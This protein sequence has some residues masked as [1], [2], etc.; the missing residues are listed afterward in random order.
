MTKESRFF[1]GSGKNYASYRPTYPPELG[2]TLAALG[3]GNEYALDVGCGNGQLTR[4]L[5]HHFRQVTGT[6]PSASQLRHAIPA[7]NVEYRQQ[8]AEAI[9]LHGASADLIVAAQAAHWFDLERFYACVRRVGNADAALALVS[10]GV[11]YLGDPVNQVFRRGYWDDLHEFWPK[12]RE[13]V[14]TAYA[15]LDFP[16][17]PIAVPSIEYRKTLTREQFTG[18]ITTWSAYEV[19]RER[20]HLDRFEAFFGQ[21]EDVWDDS[22][23][24]EIT[25]PI[26]IK[27][28]RIHL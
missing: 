14:E 27:A 22:D 28:G 2:K 4:L 26:T 23:T 16:F 1:E 10:Y 19:A 7:P 9:D 17:S 24:Q 20:G 18:Y 15:K 5:G 13:H 6:D 25:W 21:L 12:E 8:A 11:P 3:G